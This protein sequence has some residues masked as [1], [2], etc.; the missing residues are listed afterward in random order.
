MMAMVGCRHFSGYKPCG[1]NQA[2][3]PACQHLD[4]V[5]VRVLVVA[6]E[7][8]GAVLRITSLLAPIRRKF[9]GAHITWVTQA[10]A[11][12][13]LIGNPLIDRV[14]TTQPS[15]LLSLSALQFD[16]AFV[17][18]KS[19]RA[20]G[21]LRQTQVDHIFGFQ[22][23]AW[24]GAIQPATPAAQELWELG[25]ND[26]KK[27]FVN[28]KSEAQLMTE[29]MELSYRRDP[30][31]LNLSASEKREVQRRKASW[32]SNGEILVGLN[33]GCSGAV[34]YKKMSV[35]AHR[36][37]IRSLEFEAGVR[38]VLLGG[39]ED[40]ERNQA[41]GSGFDVIQSETRNGLRDGVLS[42]AAC[43]VIVTG[44]SLGLHMGVALRKW[45]VA[46]FG[47][48]CAHE[49]D[50]Y[51]RGQKVMAKVGCGPCWKRTCHNEV[52][53]YDRVD[54]AELVSAIRAGVKTIAAESNSEQE[55]SPE[56][57]ST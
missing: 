35:E 41:I 55:R 54:T 16:V 9:P 48:T 42:V 3:D 56:S 53:C 4:L 26:H 12:Q 52:M 31:I 14:L 17:T 34:P 39:R 33:T 20:S 25:L 37:L 18:D 43:D 7:A 27:F 13:L 21:V 57:L 15:D 45:V 23:D 2:C 22:A 1:L 46:W 38:V 8:L 19:L 32:A 30:Y 51:D 29:A 10:P 28:Q 49:I 40:T 50:L 11:D 24:S 47:P 6:L 44:D 36:E 5:K